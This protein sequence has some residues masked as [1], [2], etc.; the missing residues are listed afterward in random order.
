[1]SINL[2]AS[3]LVRFEGIDNACNIAGYMCD[4]NNTDMCVDCNI[5]CGRGENR[6][7]NKELEELIN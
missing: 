2:V 6:F 4:N 3:L 5:Y 1:M 7:A